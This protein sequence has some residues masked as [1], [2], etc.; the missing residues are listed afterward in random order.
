MTSIGQRI[1]SLRE[2]LGMS[3]ERLA[4]LLGVVRPTIS[5]IENG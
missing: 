1:K 4:K 3:Q 2:S 5:Q